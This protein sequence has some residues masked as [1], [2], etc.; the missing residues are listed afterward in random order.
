M[1]GAVILAC[2]SAACLTAAC[3]RIGFSER[4]GTDAPG[5]TGDGS[6]S[7]TGDGS[8]SV[9]MWTHLTAYADSTCAVRNGKVY[10]W[11]DN[12]SGQLGNS[13]GGFGK[14][15]SLV[16]LPTTNAVT[17]LSVGTVSACAIAGGTLYCWGAIG[18][19]GPTSIQLVGAATSVSVGHG[20]QCVIAGDAF[21][22]GTING[23]GQLGVGDT[24]T[25]A[26]PTAVMHASPAYVA[27][28]V[29]DDHSCAIDSSGKT[30]CWGHNDDGCIGLPTATS[31][32][33][34]PTQQ[35]AII[36]TLPQIAGWHTCAM[37]M[38]GPK[39]KCWGEGNN[40]ENGDG[41]S[42]NST[43][44]L[45]VANLTTPSFIAT[46]G[47]PADL[48]ASCAIDGGSVSCWGNGLFG[49]LGQGT[50]NPSST[51]IAVVGL[52]A[53]AAT[54]VA[55]G[56]DHACAALVDGDMYCWGRGDTG[57]LGDGNGASSLTPV[58][59]VNPP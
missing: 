15:P 53:V 20:F 34:T 38:P 3:G 26:A 49:R 56:Y 41:T 45:T 2:L 39:A 25:R 55:I 5:T 23:T 48:D 10:C 12:T 43:M 19:P 57:Q 4:A 27:I 33:L 16:T 17:D 13:A 42:T 31:D 36:T 37:S 51:P 40:G 46:G 21:C 50:A 6:G 30:W 32:S 8:S 28:E 24:N 1:R 7:S 35:N 47:G 18:S 22:W 59:V 44:P 29:G 58:K 52:P 54:E 11:G 14:S 9:T